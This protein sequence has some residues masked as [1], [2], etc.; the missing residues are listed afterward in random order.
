V[1]R[2]VV[3]A[4]EVDLADVDA[5]RTILMTDMWLHRRPARLRCPESLSHRAM[6]WAPMRP[7]V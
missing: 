3:G 2:V 1:G 5:V 4:A 6:A 7:R